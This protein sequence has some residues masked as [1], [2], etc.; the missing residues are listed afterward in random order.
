[1]TLVSVD[2]ERTL[3]VPAGDGFF[4]GDLA[5]APPSHEMQCECKCETETAPLPGPITVK[6]PDA[7]QADTC[8]CATLNDISCKVGDA[9]GTTAECKTILAAVQS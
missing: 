1:V 6:R 3:V 8:P 2:G 4:V 7:T 5:L 9:T